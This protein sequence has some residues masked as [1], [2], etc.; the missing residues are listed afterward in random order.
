MYASVFKIS[1]CSGFNFGGL[2][3]KDLLLASPN[4][5]N[6]PG[7][8]STIFGEL[9]PPAK[10]QFHNC[11]STAL[12]LSSYFE[13]AS[14][15]VYSSIYGDKMHVQL[16]AAVILGL[17]L[18]PAPVLVVRVLHRHR[19]SRPR[20]NWRLRLDLTQYSKVKPKVVS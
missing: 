8:S 12:Q 19:R 16:M 3:R 10:T 6:F 1:A 13:A 5:R 2:L 14:K 20:Q 9:R 7:G 15:R 18:S 11:R 17:T 4:H